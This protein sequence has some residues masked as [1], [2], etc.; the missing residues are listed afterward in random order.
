M[1]IAFAITEY[2]PF[3]GAQRDFI[4]VVMAM[5]VRGHEISIISTAWQG[6][7]N[8][9]WHYLL[10]DHQQ[11]TNHGRMRVLS[12]Y[13]VELKKQHHFDA[14]VGFTKMSG[15]DIYFAAD[16][17]FLL[18]KYR[19]VNRFLPRYR[20]Y[21]QIEQSLFGNP[22]LKVFYLTQQQKQQYQTSYKTKESNSVLLPV[23]VDDKY[24]FSDKLW[25]E[26]REWRSCSQDV[27]QSKIVLLFVAADFKTKGLDRIIDAFKLLDKSKQSR[28]TLWIVGT[29]KQDRY[30]SQLE[31]IPS[32]TYQFFGGQSELPRFY[33][34]AD[35]LLHPARKEA[36]GMVIAEA[37]AARLPVCVTELCGYA[38]LAKDD[39]ASVILESD[40][41][42]IQLSE[43]LDNTS[44]SD[45]IDQRGQGSEQIQNT[46]RA[47]FCA[48]QIEMW[49]SK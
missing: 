19:G 6:E 27:E 18:T 30:Q 31:T 41:V 48:D 8:D 3:G 39:P 40:N 10:L 46:S 13:V 11:K 45:T 1:H 20:T 24:F 5:A 14:V 16:P 37:L 12:K 49:L 7:K 25:Q 34:A 33:L 2:F 15:L 36:A 22:D 32:L 38:F 43:F 42:V 35:F 9:S 28:F 21:S 47:A 17:C 23:C 26:A 29:G 4:G 44:S